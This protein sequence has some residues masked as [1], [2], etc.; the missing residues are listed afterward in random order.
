MTENITEYNVLIRCDGSRTLGLGHVSRCLALAETLRDFCNFKVSFAMIENGVGA[1][2]VKASA[3]NVVVKPENS[4]EKEWLLSTIDE[5]KTDCLILDIISL[6]E[7]SLLEE[8]KKRDVVIVDIDDAD[9]KRLLADLN[10]YP[11]IPQVE[12]MDWHGFSGRVFSG[13]DWVILKKEFAKRINFRANDKPSI[14]ITMGGSDPK[15]MTLK[16][17][18]AL[19]SIE[20]DFDCVVVLGSLFAFNDELAKILDIKDNRFSILRNINN[21]AELM[22]K[23]DF[24][25]ASFGVTAYELAASGVPAIYF[26]LT[27]NHLLDLS[28]FVKDG[29]AVSLGLVDEVD[30]IKIKNAVNDFLINPDLL[31]K[32]KKN[33][34]NKV[35][36]KGTFRISAIIKETIDERK[37]KGI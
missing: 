32:M 33:M 22:A 25:V 18:R 37:K 24:A 23:S 7:N 31:S 14:L 9:N 6:V 28:T 17:V 34:K 16:A 21:M 26:G 5:Q 2:M 19:I 20:K 8:V 30:E 15:G 36:A 27:E 10:F 3:F 13:W 11:P 35:D 1:D 12:T 29:M 4:F